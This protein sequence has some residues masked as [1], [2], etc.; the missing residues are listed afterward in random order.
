MAGYAHLAAD[1]WRGSGRATP[2]ALTL[3][4]NHI[5]MEILQFL[6]HA[7][8]RKLSN[9]IRHSPT[10]YLRIK[11]ANKYNRPV[12]LAQ[13]HPE[14]ECNTKFIMV[15]NPGASCKVLRA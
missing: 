7:P 3:D 4:I 1:R 14:A 6:Q 8:G 5:P 11:Q 15:A 13:Q 9:S 10:L 2:L 12:V